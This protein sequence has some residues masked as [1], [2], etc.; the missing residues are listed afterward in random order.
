MVMITFYSMY[1]YEE[2]NTTPI[3]NSVNPSEIWI[4]PITQFV[5]IT[6]VEE[7][8]IKL[9]SFSLDQNYPNPFNPSTI[10]NYTLA[11]R[12][13]VTLKVYDVLGKEVASL[14]NNSQ[15]AGTHQVTFD[16]SNLASG[17][18]IYT[19]NAGDFSSSKKM[20]LMK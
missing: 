16:A 3:T 18:Y 19:L 13:N 9:N 2:G 10:V 12:S 7:E 6:G 14:V 15:E 1:W 11:E 8:G 4:A 17:L 20:M 5:P